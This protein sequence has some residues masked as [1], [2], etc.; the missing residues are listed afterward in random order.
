MWHGDERQQLEESR[1]RFLDLNDEQFNAMTE[2]DFFN[3]YFPLKS[4]HFNAD[5][6]VLP[7]D[8]DPEALERLND[9]ICH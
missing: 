7:S 8:T 2:R 6:Y 3:D 9:Y 5:E 4:R 1:S